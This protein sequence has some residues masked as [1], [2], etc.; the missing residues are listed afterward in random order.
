[1]SGAWHRARGWKT[2]QGEGLPFGST[3]EMVGGKSKTKGGAGLLYYTHR[4]VGLLQLGACKMIFLI[5]F[6]LPSD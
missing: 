3:S 5:A 4:A 2:L 6:T 1:M